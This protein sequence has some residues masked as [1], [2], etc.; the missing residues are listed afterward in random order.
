MK[1]LKDEI[2]EMERDFNIGMG[3][4]SCLALGALAIGCYF[5]F[6]DRSYYEELD[7][8]ATYLSQRMGKYES[9]GYGGA[10]AVMNGGITPERKEMLERIA[11]MHDYF[12]NAQAPIKTI[13]QYEDA[14][15]ILR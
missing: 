9:V 13:K 6:K 5:S 8:A 12:L 1:N 15:R 14:I 7:R 2:Q 11:I 4:I 3:I 10:L